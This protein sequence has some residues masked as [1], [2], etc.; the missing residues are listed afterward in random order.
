MN[1][2]YSLTLMALF[3][4]GAL[5]MPSIGRADSSIGAGIS[6]FQTLGDIEESEE[7]DESSVSVTLS[8][9]IGMA[10]L[11]SLEV[12]LDFVPDYGGSDEVLYMPQAFLLVGST[13]YAGAGVGM[14]YIDGDSTDAFYG[15]RVGLDLPLGESLSF[16]INANYRF[17]DVDAIDDLDSDD[18]DSI[19]FGA[20]LRL[21]L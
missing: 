15:F 20:I 10:D 13:L 19:T 16:D 3:V 2:K 21:A 12:D 9:K 17:M 4:S 7:F 11:I 8:Y 1:K 5:F 14:G 6:Y 18:A